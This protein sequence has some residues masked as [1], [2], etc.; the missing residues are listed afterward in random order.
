M[1]IGCW[2]L[3][4]WG[5]WNTKYCCISCHED[6]DEGYVNYL[7]SLGDWKTTPIL[8]EYSDVCCAVSIIFEGV[9]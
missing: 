3:E 8:Y 5:M 2:A 6:Q 1:I 4:K 9:R 7:L